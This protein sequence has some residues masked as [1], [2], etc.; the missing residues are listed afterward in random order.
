MT[1]LAATAHSY[2]AAGHSPS[3]V[4]PTL[5]TNKVRFAEIADIVQHARRTG[6]FMSV[7]LRQAEMG[8]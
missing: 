7:L 4:T 3:C 2:A 1:P 6:F 5:N 8:R